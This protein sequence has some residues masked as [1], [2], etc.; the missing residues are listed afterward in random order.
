MELVPYVGWLIPCSL[1]VYCNFTNVT[2]PVS[3]WSGEN[4]LASF[5]NDACYQRGNG[6]LLV[7]SCFRGEL[8]VKRGACIKWT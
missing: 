8:I 5:L 6:G 4:S 1:L 7:G 3:Q 2:K